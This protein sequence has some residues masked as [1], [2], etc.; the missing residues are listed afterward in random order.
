MNEVVRYVS[1]AVNVSKRWALDVAVTINEL[2]LA[3]KIY[4]LLVHIFFLALL[5]VIV[6]R[7]TKSRVVTAR[8]RTRTVRVA[9]RAVTIESCDWLNSTLQWLFQNSV[10]GRTPDLIRL[11]IRALNR[12]LLRDRK[13]F[14]VWWLIISL[15]SIGYEYDCMQSHVIIFIPFQTLINSSVRTPKSFS[16]FSQFFLFF[17]TILDF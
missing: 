11:W 17:Q 5:V 4:L 1:V 12:Q 7:K 15:N 16:F 3:V 6:K 8:E 10:T 14:I 2:N 9:D 13:V